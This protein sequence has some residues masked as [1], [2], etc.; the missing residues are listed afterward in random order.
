MTDDPVS[1]ARQVTVAGA[2]HRPRV[3]ELEKIGELMP[4]ETNEL[5]TGTIVDFGG[6]QA[7]A[8]PTRQPANIVAGWMGSGVDG[9]C[10]MVVRSTYAWWMY[11]GLGN[12][13]FPVCSRWM[14][15]RL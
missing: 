5:T 9:V 10:A 12:D 15:D 14:A 3:H 4:E 2:M 7:S 11:S 13:I 1:G 8:S 6:V